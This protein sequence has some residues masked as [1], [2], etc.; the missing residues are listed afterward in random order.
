MCAYAVAT[1]GAQHRLAPVGFMLL[2]LVAVAVPLLLFMQH[3]YGGVMSPYVLA[4][5]ENGFS[6]SDLH[7]R[8]Y[9]MLLRSEDT[10]GE[11]HTTLFQLQPWL[12]AAVPLAI[13]WACLSSTPSRSHR[14]GRSMRLT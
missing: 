10:Y 3:A 14:L 8:A 4:S 5:R 1:A 6:F 11:S 2:G 7:E 12:H 9:E 13:V